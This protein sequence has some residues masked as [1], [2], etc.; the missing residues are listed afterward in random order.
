MELHGVVWW[1]KAT[2][3]TDGCFQRIG[4]HQCLSGRVVQ[5]VVFGVQVALSG[6]LRGRGGWMGL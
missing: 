5:V 4:E 1:W 3:A 2:G 6:F